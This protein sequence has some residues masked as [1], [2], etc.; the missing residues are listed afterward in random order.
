MT[1]NAILDSAA[2]A[3]EGFATRL[4]RVLDLY[5][6]RRAAAAAAQVSTDQLARYVQ[7]RSAPPFEV[8][9]RLAQP[10]AVSLDWLAFGEG[11]MH[12]DRAGAEVEQGL[13]VFGLSATGEAGWYR[14]TALGV[15]L[16]HASG[17]RPEETKAVLACDDALR[18]EG[19]RAGFICYASR[20][21]ELL[22]GDVCYLE[23]GDGAAGLRRFDGR[24]GNG[25]RL[26]WYA[27]PDG[28]GRQALTTDL[29][30]ETRVARLYPVVKVRRK[31]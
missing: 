23:R 8:M 30:P 10:H 28:D 12:L 2:E 25:F 6:T 13:T 16:P 29:L 5:P 4:S 15:R 18:P 19:I 27:P 24:E 20:A 21:V 14:P 3:L 26:S 22:E 11:A 1:V 17:L 7:S 9:A 31:W